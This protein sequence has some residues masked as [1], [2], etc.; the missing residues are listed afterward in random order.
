MFLLFLLFSQDL[1]LSYTTY[2]T[3]KRKT[4]KGKRYHIVIRL[5]LDECE[6]FGTRCNPNE[7]PEM[8]TEHGA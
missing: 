5:K 7:R 2:F 4:Y 6:N 8:Q 3:I 1:F